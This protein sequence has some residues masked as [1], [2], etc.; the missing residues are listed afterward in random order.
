[1]AGSWRNRAIELLMKHKNLIILIAFCLFLAFL[2]NA[3][4]FQKKYQIGYWI[5]AGI[6]QSDAPDDSDLY[7]YQGLISIRN[8]KVFHKRLGLYPH[9]IKSKNLYLVYRLEGDLSNITDIISIFERSAKDWMRH[10]K[11]IAGFQLDFDSPTNKLHTYSEFLYNLR[12]KLSSNYSLSVTGLVDWAISG[13]EESLRRISDVTD[14]LVF[15]LY[16]GRS[17]FPQIDSYVKILDTYPFAFKIGLLKA[18]EYKN[19][20]K[21]LERNPQFKG[22]IYFIQKNQ[23]I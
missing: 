3:V 23:R 12:E 21:T 8:G 22:I 20:L 16:Q 11:E 15:Q 19:N 17:I 6:T 7:V 18:G 13:D 14:G 10:K 5:W 2:V 9:P 4:F 1:M